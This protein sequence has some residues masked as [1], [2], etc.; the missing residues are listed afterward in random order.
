MNKASEIT[1]TQHTLKERAGLPG[2]PPGKSEKKIK[3]ILKF[4]LPAGGALFI[5]VA[6]LGIYS[7]NAKTFEVWQ[8]TNEAARTMVHVVHPARTTEEISLQLAG[9]TTPYT[10]APIFAQTKGYLQK[11]YFDIGVNCAKAKQESQ[12]ALAIIRQVISIETHK[13]LN[14]VDEGQI[15]G[16][17]VSLLQRRFDINPQRAAQLLQRLGSIFKTLNQTLAMR[18]NAL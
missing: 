15:R 12:G 11:W 13:P 1:V 5:G 8:L 14:Q 17:F 9:Q 3:R 2:E 16:R 18:L 7:R 10:D 6:V 4:F